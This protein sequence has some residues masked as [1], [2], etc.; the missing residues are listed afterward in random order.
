MVA[1]QELREP[2]ARV[3]LP[4]LQAQVE[5]VAS[6]EHLASPGQAAHQDIPV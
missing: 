6:L 1:G 3:G 2:R 4:V 5:P